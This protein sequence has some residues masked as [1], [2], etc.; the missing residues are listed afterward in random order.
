VTVYLTG[1]TLG[2]RRELMTQGARP[3]LVRYA[4][5]IDAA[6]AR[7]RRLGLVGASA[8]ASAS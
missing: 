7:A 3:P 8:G 6:L 2:L 4:A 5:G 1:T